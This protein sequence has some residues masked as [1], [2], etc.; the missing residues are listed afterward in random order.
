MNQTK[1]LYAQ[2]I[3]VDL[4]HTVEKC[5]LIKAG[6]SESQLSHEICHIASVEFGIDHHWHKKIVRAGTNT[7]CK[8]TDNPPDVVIHANDMVILDFGPIVNGYE[9]DLGRTYV[10]GAHP[11]K[12]KMKAD[13]EKAWYETQEWYRSHHSLR[14]SELFQF[15]VEKAND[16]GYTLGGDIAG[17]IVGKYPHEQPAD[18]RSPELDIHP[19]NHNDLF[20]PGF[21]GKQRH[22]ILE[23]LFIDKVNGFG[24]YF[25]QLL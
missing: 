1:L 18:P 3:A 15:A 11:G 10:V 22:W 16:Y 17:H 8:Y 14:G 19:E 7:L 25:E 21:D 23:L 20:L 6:K 24:A 2:N 5:G 13:V 9:A 4:F 12:I